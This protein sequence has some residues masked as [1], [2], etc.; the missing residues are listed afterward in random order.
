[1]VL[2]DLADRAVGAGEQRDDARHGPGLHLGAA[3]GLRHRDGEEPGIRELV[4]LGMREDAVA[5]A[6]AA[7]SREFGRDLAGD[8]ERLGIVADAVAARRGRGT[9]R[10]SRSARCRL[11][12][13]VT[14]SAHAGRL[15][16]AG[17]GRRARASAPGMARRRDA[18]ERWLPTWKY[19]QRTGSCSVWVRALRQCRSRLCARA[20]SGCRRARAACW[21]PGSRSRWSAPWLRR[22]RRSPRRS[23]PSLGSSRMPSMARPAMLQQG[24]GGMQLDLEIADLRGS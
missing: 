13:A 9:R 19:F 3:V 2:R 6:P 4:E 1:M 24:L 11:R 14:G 22:P 7:P 17:R 12:S 21:W 16:N 10:A 8:R 23:S 5:V 15:A 20:S 18:V